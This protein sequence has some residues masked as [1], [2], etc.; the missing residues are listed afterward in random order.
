MVETAKLKY[1]MR[2]GLWVFLALVVLAVAEY[3]LAIFMTRGNLPYMVIMNLVDAALIA[4]F[5]MHIAQLW[6]REE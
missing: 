2:R 6:R 1:A 3:A 4:Y 5:F